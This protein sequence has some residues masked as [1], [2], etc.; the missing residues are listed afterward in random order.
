MTENAAERAIRL[1]DL[2][3]FILE[4]QG[5]SIKQLAGSFD[6]SKEEIIKDLNLLFVCGLPGYTPLELID[7]SFEDEVVFI[8]DPQNLAEPRNLTISESIVTRIALSA[9]KE[10]ITDPE[11]KSVISSLQS[12]LS[13]LFQ[14][15]LPEN[16]L[17]VEIDKALQ[18]E[19][20]I[21]Q[22]IQVG[23]TV[24]IE[25][26]NLTKDEVS[27]RDIS[28]MELVK[29]DD[30]TTLN[31]FCHKVGAIR[32][33]AVK[34]I[35]SA[36]EM[37][38]AS[39]TLQSSNHGDAGVEVQIRSMDANSAMGNKL[40][41]DAKQIG[42]NIY[43]IKVFQDRWLLRTVFSRPTWEILQPVELRNHLRNEARQALTRYQE[44]SL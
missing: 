40:N 23:K 35:M 24:R 15:V 38:E 31:A 14:S 11:K 17:H 2:V 12:K 20:V 28:P 18:V 6:V 44:L 13:T 21:Q 39:R 8:R 27:T 30:G 25:Y 22:A 34:Q 9:L 4:N 1:L 5:I 3:P 10:L 16:A 36:T 7:I 29:R 43:V 26:L 37:T 41:V 42:N 32:S 19:R 33:F